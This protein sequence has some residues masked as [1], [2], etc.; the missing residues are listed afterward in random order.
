MGKQSPSQFRACGTAAKMWAVI[1]GNFTF[2]TRAC[3]VNSRIVL[4]TT[5]NGDLSIVNYINKMHIFGDELATVGKPIDVDDLISYIL[6]GL[7]FEYN[8][9]VTTLV[10]KENVTHGEVYAQLLSFKQ[11]LELQRSAEHYANV[12]SHG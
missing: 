6:T 5:M 10:T 12:A 3:T 7:D 8:S 1:E 4:A 2:A 11:R 9:V